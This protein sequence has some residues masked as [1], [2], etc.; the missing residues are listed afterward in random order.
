MSASLSLCLPTIAWS[1]SS[2]FLL[3]APAVVHDASALVFTLVSSFRSA[4]SSSLLKKAFCAGGEGASVA[5]RVRQA[6]RARRS[7]C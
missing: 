4:F 1:A 6:S 3:C 2:S 5:C 7:S